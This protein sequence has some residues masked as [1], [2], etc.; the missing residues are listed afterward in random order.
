MASQEVYNRLHHELEERWPVVAITA[1]T[2][3]AALVLP[4]LMKTNHLKAIPLVGG[5]QFSFLKG[6]WDVYAQGYNKFKK[7]TFRIKS[8]RKSP[9]VVVSPVF[10]GELK[11]LPDDV[12]SFAKSVDESMQTKYTG[13]EADVPAIPH[14]VKT[15][16]TPALVRLN[17]TISDEVVESMRMELPQTSNWEEVCIND[18]LLRI[19]A[20]ASGRIFIGPELCRDERY[21]DAS[22]NYT[23]DLMT[24]VHL[25]SFTPSWLRPLVAPIL[26]PVR[27]LH[28]RIKEADAFLRPVVAARREAAKSPDY[29]EPDDML[30]WLMNSQAKFGAKNDKELAKNQLGISFAAIHTTTLTTLNAFYNLAADPSLVPMLREDVQQAL[31]ET[32]GVFTNIALQ[33][34]KKLDSFLKETLRVY[35]LGAASFQRM[36]LKDFTLSNGQVIPAGCIIEVPSGIV[37]VDPEVHDSPEQFD[38]LRYYNMRIAKGEQDSATKTAE[39][40]A[41]SQF[42]SVG[43]SSLTFGYGRHA[44]PGR[45]FAVNEIKMIMATA[46]LHY[47]VKNVEGQEERIPNWKFGSQ[48]IPDSKGKILMR[49]L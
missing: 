28:R 46:L 39:V 11:K 15:G 45:F 37:N 23:I 35:P 44:C 8:A 2:L 43:T 1:L 31:A 14:V 13:V 22:I 38:A 20:M 21:L 41:N 5:G 27:K 49:K 6:G 18:K 26:P 10:L 9:I 48:S 40:V 25:I 16:L 19:V 4:G 29:Q 36:V 33:N 34:M 24:A 47:D 42:V 12:L 30:Q 32:D 17:P 7:S 3:L